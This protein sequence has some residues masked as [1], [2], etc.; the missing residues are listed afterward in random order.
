MEHDPGIELTPE[1]RAAFAALPSERVPSRLLEERTVASL[2]DAGWLAPPS[3]TRP[4][5]VGWLSGGLAA[6]LVLLATG[7]AAG[8]WVGSHA[9]VGE[10]AVEAR[11]PFAS[12]ARVQQTGTAYIEALAQLARL[13][14]SNAT[15]QGREAAMAALRTALAQLEEMGQRDSAL[16]DSRQQI[17]GRPA[18]V[19]QVVWF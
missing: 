15:A 17:P 9:V 5:V 16:A 6:A 4:G 10:P 11:D 8:Q 7:F 1:E 13:A 3:R 19:I 14:D 2:R 18:D 12:A